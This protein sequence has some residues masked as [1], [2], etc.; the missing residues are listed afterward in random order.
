MSDWMLLR[1]LLMFVSV[2][3]FVIAVVL[4]G[5]LDRRRETRYRTVESTEQVHDALT[6]QPCARCDAVY[7]RPESAQRPEQDAIYKRAA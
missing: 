1:L 5:L 3:L 6:S 7:R 2:A 4:V